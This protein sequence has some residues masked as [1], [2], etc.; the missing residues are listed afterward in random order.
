MTTQKVY[1]HIQGATKGTL[2][3]SA[4]FTDGTEASIS[5]STDATGVAQ[6]LGDWGGQEGFTITHGLCTAA[7]VPNYCRILSRDGVTK[8]IIPIATT[9][10]VDTMMALPKPVQVQQGDLLRVLTTA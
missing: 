5:T 1:V 10:K 4:S 6:S 7:T 9:G 8:G 2:F 3:Y